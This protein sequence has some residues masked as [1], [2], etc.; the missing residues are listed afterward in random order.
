[1]PENNKHSELKEKCIKILRSLGYTVDTSHEEK[2]IVQ[3]Y[4]EYNGEKIAL[5]DVDI[6]GIKK[7]AIQM[8]VEIEE[9]DTPK[10]VLGDVAVVD[11]ANLCLARMAGSDRKMVPLTG[12]VLFIVTPASK[13][14]ATIKMLRDSYDFMSGSLRDFIV[15]NEDEI[16]DELNE[17]ELYMV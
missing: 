11:M 10:T 2:G 9:D 16:E 5:A 3:I 7:G 8:I 12:V 14:R 6:V 15:T 13:E 1:M 17:M 4:R